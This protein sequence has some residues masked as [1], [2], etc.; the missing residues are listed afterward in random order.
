MWPA[1]RQIHHAYRSGLLEHILKIMDVAYSSRTPKGASDLV[2]AG[3]LLHD[4]GKLLELDYD[5]A[6]D[7]SFEGNLLGHIAMGARWC[8]MATR[9]SRGFRPNSVELEHLV[10]SHHGAQELGSPVTP[11][12]LEA[13]ILAAA[14]DLDATLHQVRRHIADDDWDGPFTTYNGISSGY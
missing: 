3:A 4:I 12:T 11:M 1:A 14:D 9:S 8:E 6:I 5:V 7:Y 10:L 2:I 13:L